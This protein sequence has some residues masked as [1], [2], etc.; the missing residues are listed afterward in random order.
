MAGGS[1]SG[2][3]IGRPGDERQSMPGIKMDYTG[4]DSRDGESR[5][6]THEGKFLNG[7][8]TPRKDAPNANG[9]ASTSGLNGLS[10]SGAVAAPAVSHPR[11]D[12]LPP[13]LEHI[14]DDCYHPLSKLLER[15]AL[16]TFSEIQTLLAKMAEMHAV[17]HPNGLLANGQG[18]YVNG[19][20]DNS[21]ANKQKK[22]M[23]M[24]FSQ[25]NR[26]K[27]IKLLVLTQWGKKSAADIMKL[28]DLFTYLRKKSQALEHTD[29]VLLGMKDWLA[30][31]R[32][33]N[34]DI[35]TALPILSLGKADW[36]PD[37]GYIPK[38]PLSP[39]KALKLLKNLNVSA[40]VRLTV[41]EDLPRHLKKWHVSDGKATFVVDSEFEMDVL[42][43]NEDA[44]EQWHFIDFRLL[45]SPAPAIEVGGRFWLYFKP[46]VDGKLRESG[47][48]GCFE[49]L[50][51]YVLTHKI[52]ILKSQAKELARTRWAGTLRVEEIHRMLAVQ[53]WIGKSGRKSWIEIGVSS[54]RPSNG[55]TS[56][57]GS[58]LSVLKIR[59]HRNGELVPDVKLDVDWKNLSM[60]RIL[61]QVVALHTGHLLQ[62]IQR[63]LPPKL[64]VK[65]THSRIE[66]CDCSLRLSLGRTE[67]QT[68]ITVEPV[69]GK[70]ILQPR[71]PISSRTEHALNSPTRFQPGKDRD[72]TSTYGKIITSLLAQTLHDALEQHA[73][74]LGWHSPTRQSLKVDTLKDATKLGVL[75]YA[76]YR[77][78]GWAKNFAL[79]P[80]ID[81]SGESWWFLE[82]DAKN[83][84]IVQAE[85]LQLDLAGR[86]PRINRTTLASIER[87]AVQQLSFFATRRECKRRNLNSL[88]TI[89]TSTPSAIQQQLGAS[90]SCVRGWVL[91][92]RTA[93]LLTPKTGE[94]PWLEPTIRVTCQ[95]VKGDCRNVSH[96]AS[97]TMVKAVVADMLRLMASSPQDHF[98]FSENGNF[99]ILL[100]TP[101][102]EPIL[103][104]LSARLR[105]LDRLRAFASSLERRKMKLKSSSL[106]EISFQYGQS[107][108]ATVNFS[109]EKNIKVALSPGNPH[110]RVR[111]HLVDIINER[112]PFQLP[113]SHI[114]GPDRFCAYLMI[115]RPILSALTEL[116]KTAL[117]DFRNPSIHVH[118]IGVYRI[119]YANPLCSFDLKLKIKND[120]LFWQVEDNERK[121]ADIRPIPERLPTRARLESLKVGLRKLFREHGEGWIGTRSG[122]IAEIDGIPDALRKLH[123]TIKAAAVEGDALPYVE[124][125]DP[126][127]PSQQ[128]PQQH[129]QQQQHM[130]QQQM[131]QQQQ[132]QRQG[133]GPPVGHP[134]MGRG[135]QNHPGQ[136]NARHQQQHQQGHVKKQEV[137]E[138]D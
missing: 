15:M 124:V 97:G 83:I 46:L 127:P 37:L 120:N 118:E 126:H 135:G 29:L 67:N 52:N 20:P 121:P 73:S 104:E 6:R 129:L 101:F 117:R 56:W 35:K 65:A 16:E 123:Q 133:G 39:A 87:V 78:N 90:Q 66:P 2:A 81:A 57:R 30:V 17:Q 98:T 38:G 96:I 19:L 131:Q 25:S 58:P 34:P 77:P 40:S 130:Q 91:Q 11:M 94:E 105:D 134:S 61:K 75:A 55:K 79:V 27:F 115:T 43:F 112:T 69:T 31:A 103:S 4:A 85:Q 137:I 18:G 99:A 10:A 3:R 63:N 22:M 74:Q 107:Y 111:Y 88:L 7:D 33:Y 122:I 93:D 24:Q 108:S 72:P 42:T 1:S 116:E 86:R 100:T 62:T 82:L 76:M 64:A 49:W 128:H 60:E 51:N 84:N 92:L 8:R 110:N 113:G 50:H 109:Q 59:W 47:L 138:L 80:I 12:E 95:G 106:Q 23:L 136:A 28:I 102:G 48:E 89:E 21:E 114:S 9:S 71:G 14:G 125:P 119:T 132:Q 44:S 36:I 5:K 26:A 53:Y 32:Q 54:E 70:Y 41:H 13:E 45:F 68:I